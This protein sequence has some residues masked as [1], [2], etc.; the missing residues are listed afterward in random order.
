MTLY[1]K[2]IVCLSLCMV[3]T[4]ISNDMTKHCMGSL[5]SLSSLLPLTCMYRKEMGSTGSSI[6]ELTYITSLSSWFP[7]QKYHSGDKG[8]VQSLGE[9][10]LQ[11]EAFRTKGEWPHKQG[12]EIQPIRPFQ[13][14]LLL[15]GRPGWCNRVGRKK[16]K[17]Y[18]YH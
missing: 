12:D 6:G 11:V 8:V 14:D 15:L 16:K 9:E 10:L 17:K 7:T 3:P 2:V 5:R 1:L 13:F 18:E 4:R